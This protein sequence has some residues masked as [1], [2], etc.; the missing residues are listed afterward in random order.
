MFKM[1]KQARAA[2]GMLS[3]DEVRQRAEKPV[4]FGLVADST[5][6][7][8]EMEAFLVPGH[9][10]RSERLALI[11]RIHRA[12]DPEPP[13]QVDIV[14]YEP[15][16]ACPEGAYTY[17]RGSPEETVAEILA[18]KDEISLALARQYPVFRSA[19]IDGLIHEVARENTIFAVTTAL[20]NIVPNFIEVPWLFGEFA[21]DTA[22]LTANQMRMA[23]QI[24]GA[25]GRPVG[26][27][28]QKFE[29]LGIAGGAFGWRALARELV[30]HVPFGGGLIP[31]GAIAYAGTYLAG[32]GLERL[33]MGGGRH[34]G[35][36]QRSL[37]QRG[38]ERGKLVVR[39]IRAS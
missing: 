27:K 36:E 13:T 1:I 35:E 25:C 8:A 24:A 39:E 17:H 34:T 2:I 15:G 10:E 31:K 23:F 21:S 4:H 38:L 26:L 14:L 30:G 18:D 6:A 3:A 37:Y 11:E 28:E 33:H 29:M 5:G 7:Y 16:L 19:V 22:F 12:H 9:L 20:P 32:K